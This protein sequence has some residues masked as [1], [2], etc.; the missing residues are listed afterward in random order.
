MRCNNT[1]LQKI[2]SFLKSIVYD[3]DQKTVR[4]A[5][6]DSGE[7]EIDLNNGEV[8]KVYEHARNQLYE[9]RSDI[10]SWR[11][12]IYYYKAPWEVI[13][14]RNG[15]PRTIGPY[16]TSNDQYVVGFLVGFK[17]IDKNLLIEKIS[18]RNAYVNKSNIQPIVVFNMKVQEDG[19]GEFELRSGNGK[20]L[21]GP[22]SAKFI[23]DSKEE[24]DDFINRFKNRDSIITISYVT[25]IKTS[26]LNEIILKW[27]DVQ[28]SKIFQ[29]FSGP[30]GPQYITAAQT[31]DIT[32]DILNDVKLYSYIENG[33]DYFETAFNN[34]IN[35]ISSDV[36]SKLSLDDLDSYSKFLVNVNDLM[37][38]RDVIR[39]VS[40]DSK[41]LTY[42]EWCKKYLQNIKDL[43]ESSSSS[44][45][46]SSEK[47]LIDMALK[48]SFMK[49]FKADTKFK[50]Y[51]E[52]ENSSEQ[53]KYSK[54]DYEYLEY[55]QDCGKDLVSSD[56]SYSKKGEEYIPKSITVYQNLTRN[57]IVNT[58]LNIV[59]Y[60]TDQRYELTEETV[61]P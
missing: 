23:V 60:K 21:S 41:N 3:P 8:L 33:S 43:K 59:S 31:I 18:D 37:K 1:M 56:Y 45:T 54:T 53:S 10:K 55:S 36:E 38:V 32:L 16:K 40:Y 6:S 61:L 50:K 12:M 44:K 26:E 52:R 4:G 51:K 19:L 27:K 48:G 29:D 9:N 35:V 30:S 11:K 58:N 49:L 42:K 57:R 14:D 20:S 39:E 24:A 46:Y 22:V 13:K 17:K 25:L 47:D 34:L 2:I 7:M 5:M 28:K 15:L